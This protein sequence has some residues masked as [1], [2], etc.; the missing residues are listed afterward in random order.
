MASAAQA[1]ALKNYRK[2]LTKRGMARFEVLGL[3]AD[4][5]L[6]RTIAKRLAEDTPEAAEMR[7]AMRKKVTEEPGTKGDI[8]N[9]LRNSPLVGVDLNLTRPFTPGRK[10]DL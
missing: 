1:Q 3:A 6:V 10:I 2:R 7:A 9:W 4:R 5:E 8:W